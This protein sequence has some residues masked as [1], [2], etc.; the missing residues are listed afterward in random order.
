MTPRK[1]GTE[2]KVALTRID[3]PAAS[4]T[5]TCFAS[6]PTTSID[7]ASSSSI[8]FFSTS[9]HVATVCCDSFLP[10][11]AA[12]YAPASPSS[13]IASRSCDW[14][15][16]W[17]PPSRAAPSASRASPIEILPSCSAPHVSLSFSPTTTSGS[18][19]L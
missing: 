19:N 11:H 12:T 5:S 10:A 17:S 13:S 1:T 6:V 18:E 7:T 16:S 15:V 9:M 14:F 8:S 2:T 3:E 4:R